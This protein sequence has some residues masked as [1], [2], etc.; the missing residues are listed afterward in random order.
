MT[1]TFKQNDINSEMLAFIRKAK[2]GSMSDILTMSNEIIGSRKLGELLFDNGLIDFGF[3]IDREFF[4]NHYL[5][6]FDAMSKPFTLPNY[7]ILI[8]TIL[9]ES[10]D[11]TFSIPHPGHLIVNIDEIR[12]VS[13]LTSPQNFGVLIGKTSLFGSGWAVRPDGGLKARNENGFAF[14]S[15]VDY[16]VLLTSVI[17]NYTIEQARNLLKFMTTA[18]IYTE[19]NFNMQAI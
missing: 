19:F 18:G 9:G 5:A 14:R 11:V 16:G 8:N 12:D 4:I 17:S 1:Q 10:V 2:H 15:R 3:E 13:G 7:K 6:I